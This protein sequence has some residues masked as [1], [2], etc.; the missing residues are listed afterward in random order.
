LHRAS[1]NGPKQINRKTVRKPAT[2]ALGLGLMPGDPWQEKM[3]IASFV[4]ATL[5][6]QPANEEELLDNPQP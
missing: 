3:V 5:H 6:F 2:V 4:S 1:A